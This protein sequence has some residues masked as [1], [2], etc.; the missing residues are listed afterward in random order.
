MVHGYHPK[1]AAPLS[2]ERL[3]KNK[4]I[5]RYGMCKKEG[6]YVY[7][8]AIQHEMKIERS[9]YRYIPKYFIRTNST[10]F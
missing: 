2:G 1:D 9:I 5:D 3:K 6:M 8:F 4:C 10:N 7:I